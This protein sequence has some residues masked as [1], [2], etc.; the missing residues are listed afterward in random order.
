MNPMGK[1]LIKSIWRKSLW[2]ILQTILG[3]TDI[4]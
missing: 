4:K 2:T 3:N 1:K